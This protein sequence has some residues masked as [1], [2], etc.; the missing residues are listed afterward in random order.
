MRMPYAIGNAASSVTPVMISHVSLPSHVGVME[1]TIWSLDLSCGCSKSNAPT[2]RSKPS[3]KTY[4]AMDRAAKPAQRRGMSI[5]LPPHRGIGIRAV[6][7]MGTERVLEGPR[8]LSVGRTRFR[9]PPDDARHKEKKCS[10]EERVDTYK[11]DQCREER[12]RRD[13]RNR[14]DRSQHAEDHPGLTAG[15]GHIPSAKRRNNA[16][17]SHRHQ[18]AKKPLCRKKPVLPSK[19][20]RACRHSEHQDG[21]TVHDAESVKDHAHDRLRVPGSVL[22]A[23]HS[24]MK[25]VREPDAA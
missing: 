4:N 12:L 17:R 15:L 7:Y 9:T 20:Q 6:Q 3:S 23:L 13:R 11:C 2:P 8:G 10:H 1:S 22:Q 19:P 25:T 24:A 21:D 16:R 5:V 18:E 14:I